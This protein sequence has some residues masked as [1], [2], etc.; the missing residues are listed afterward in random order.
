MKN[1]IA[2]AKIALK[3]ADA[4][5][6]GASN[7]LSISEGYNIFADNEMFRR[8]FG[9]FRERYGIRSVLDGVF[10]K[11]LSQ[12]DYK[13]YTHRLVRLWVDDYTPSEVITDLRNLV[14]EI[15]CFVLTT[16]ADEHLEKAGFPA[17]EV[18]EIE[19]TFRQTRDAMLPENKQAEL[20]EFL[21]EYGNRNLVILELG[22]G[23]RN[24]II[25]LPLMQLA[26]REPNAT[27]ITL[28]LPHEIYIP[29]EIAGKS[30]AL[31]GDIADTLR[32]LSECPNN[33]TT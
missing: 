33:Q 4:I 26:L 30:I 31:P 17:E 24:R 12:E 14:G 6:I 5:L 25:K 10:A 20:N 32:K 3:N 13:Q 27:Y 1:E 21:K 11:H 18:W 19:G 28:N 29:S 23:S 2:K 9:D 15:P 7:G 8:Q 22:V 16:N